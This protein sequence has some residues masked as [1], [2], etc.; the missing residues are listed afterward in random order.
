MTVDIFER[1][2]VGMWQSMPAARVELRRNRKTVSQAL[3]SGKQQDRMQTETGQ[4]EDVNY[5]VKLLQTEESNL[6]PFNLDAV[7]EVKA[8]N[9]AE[10]RP[11]RIAGRRESGGILT[12]TL[13]DRYE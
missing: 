5:T 3:S 2:F 4:V 11:Y 10:W 13:E 7:V 12:L 6:E 8:H 9:S 1:A